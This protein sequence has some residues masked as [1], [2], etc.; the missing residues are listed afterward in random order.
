MQPY[1]TNTALVRELAFDEL[2]DH[3][4]GGITDVNPYVAAGLAANGATYVA[5]ASVAVATT[6]AINLYQPQTAAQAQVQ[7]AFQNPSMAF[8]LVLQQL[9]Q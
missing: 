9:Q 1:R 6:L 7:Y 3:F 8:D 2:R 5:P 4:G